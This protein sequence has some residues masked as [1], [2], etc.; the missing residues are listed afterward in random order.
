MTIRSL[1]RTRK[2]SMKGT[3]VTRSF[4]P[5][6]EAQGRTGDSRAPPPALPRSLPIPPP[7]V[8]PPPVCIDYSASGFFRL[9]TRTFSEL[10]SSAKP[11]LPLRA[12][13]MLSRASALHSHPFGGGA[14]V[15]RSR[16]SKPRQLSLFRL[17]S[18]KQSRAGTPSPPPRAPVLSL[19][20]LLS[21]SNHPRGG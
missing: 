19:H 5:E 21:L 4:R 9:I 20:H 10:V 2:N 1:R 3:R 18:R 17:R 11:F 13:V 15:R 8:L 14:C 16:D 6:P 12:P 7:G